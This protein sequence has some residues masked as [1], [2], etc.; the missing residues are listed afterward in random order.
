MGLFV[1]N[2]PASMKKPGAPGNDDN[3]AMRIAYTR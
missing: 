1:R 3:R 2:S